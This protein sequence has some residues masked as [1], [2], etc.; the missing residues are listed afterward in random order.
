[1][2]IERLWEKGEGES[3]TNHFK[4]YPTKRTLNYRKGKDSFSDNWNTLLISKSFFFKFVVWRDWILKSLIMEIRK[5][6]D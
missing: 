2:R 6:E 1:M 3:D 4:Y 5:Q